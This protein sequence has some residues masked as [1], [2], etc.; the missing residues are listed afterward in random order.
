[1]ELSGNKGEWAEIYALFK[2]LSDRELH[3]GDNNIDQ[4]ANLVYPI[5]D[6]IRDDAKGRLNYSYANMGDLVVIT[7]EGNELARIPV[8]KFSEY[9]AILLKKIEEG[10]KGSFEIPEV[11]SFRVDTFTEKI[12]AKSADKKDITI[13]VHDARTGV[14]PILGFS[15][16]SYLGGN[17][18]LL[19]SSG[20]TNFVFELSSQ[21]DESIISD[22]NNTRLFYNKFKILKEHGII[23]KFLGVEPSVKGGNT[24]RNNLIL[25]D[26]CMPEILANMLLV[27]Y[28]SKLIKIA[29]IVEQIKLDNPIHFDMSEGQSFY[30]CKIKRLLTDSALG[31]KPAEV[32][33][34]IYEANGG[35]LVV[36]K[37]GDIICYHIYNKKEFEDYLYNNTKFETPDPNRH[38]FGTIEKGMDGKLRI[39]LN[40]QIRFI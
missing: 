10:G 15:I 2:L 19:N 5:L 22:I 26:Y 29:D 38:H 30:E 8:M 9:A 17:P 21:L 35:Y 33:N 40:L 11:K 12:K 27:Y 3:G 25:I 31:M 7:N 4:I 39:K 14:N 28:G 23:I 13:V 1:M 24:F 16:K 20:A 18:T 6:I 32:W 37:S 36:K 34:G